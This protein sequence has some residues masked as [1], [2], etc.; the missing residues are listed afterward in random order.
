MKIAMIGAGKTGRGFIGR[1]LAEDKKEIY[2]IDKD[3]S[4]VNSLNEKK[5]FNVSFFGGVRAPFTVDNYTATTWEG[6]DLS[7]VEIIFVS[8]GG[9]NLPDVGAELRK[10]IN[11]GKMRHIIVGEN[12]SKPA[13]KLAEAI[14]LDNIT[15]SESTVFCTTIEDANSSCDLDISSENYPYLQCDAEP[16]GG[17][18]LNISTV[19]PISGFSNFLTRKLYTYN[20]ASCVIAYLGF[21]KGYTDYGTAANDEEILQLL[22][23]N[24]AATNKVLCKVYGY[25]EQDQAEFAALSKAKFTDRTIADTVSRNAREPQRKLQAAERIMGPLCLIDEHGE[26]TEPLLL[27][28][29]AALHYEHESDKGWQEIKNSKTPA[30]ILAEICGLPVGS[31]LSNEILAKYDVVKAYMSGEGKL[32]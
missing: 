32:F 20:A 18:E 24:Y 13:K 31:K 6:A 30:E 26:D 21:A 15:V 23:R 29:A 9:M 16:L 25:E 4:L 12:A 10:L 2:F 5:S 17:Y 7:D 11:D 1:L 19:R 8:V 27:T 22:D 28:A 14:G 3:E